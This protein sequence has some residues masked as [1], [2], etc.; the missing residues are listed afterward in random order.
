MLRTWVLVS[1]RTETFSKS[2]CAIN[3]ITP[4]D[5]KDWLKAIGCDRPGKEND[6]CSG[7]KQTEFALE[8]F[9]PPSHK[10]SQQSSS[11]IE[12]WSHISPASIW[13]CTS[14]PAPSFTLRKGKTQ[15]SVTAPKVSAKREGEGQHLFQQK[16]IWWPS[17]GRR[18]SSE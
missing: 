15:P 13:D 16:H 11:P 14:A 7:T 5:F 3:I 8:I 6:L 18:G 1:Y 2:H 4:I 9:W 17:R 10:C 12:Y